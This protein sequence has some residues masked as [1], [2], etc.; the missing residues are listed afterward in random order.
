MIIF[1]IDP[2]YALH[3]RYYRHSDYNSSPH[4]IK[5]KLNRLYYSV[6]KRCVSSVIF[7]KLN[8]FIMCSNFI[9]QLLLQFEGSKN[10]TGSLHNKIMQSCFHIIR[11]N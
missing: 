6:D 4:L 1:K 3:K 2:P 11:K 5:K 10:L 7:L 9:K 8:Q